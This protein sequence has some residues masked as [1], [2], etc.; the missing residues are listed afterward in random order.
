MAGVRV[1]TAGSASPAHRISIPY[2]ARET[3]AMLYERLAAQTAHT[4]FRW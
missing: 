2:L 4:A 1:D 3:A